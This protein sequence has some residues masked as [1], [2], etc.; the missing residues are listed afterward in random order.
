MSLYNP[1]SWFKKPGKKTV[2]DTRPGFTP[3]PKWHSLLA[4]RFPHFKDS[5]YELNRRGYEIIRTTDVVAQPMDKMANRIGMMVPVVVGRGERCEQ[6]QEIIDLSLGMPD[7]L[8]FLAWGVVEGWRAMWIN[9]YGIPARGYVVPDLRGGGI[10]RFQA[11]G[12][13]MWDG[14]TENNVIKVEQPTHPDERERPSYLMDR[15]RIILFRPGASINPDGENDVAYQLL[16]IAE[17]ASLL[18]KAQ[19]I[20]GERHALPREIIQ[21]L[22]ESLRPDE[23]SAAVSSAAE[24]IAATNAYEITGLTTEQVLKYLEPSGTTWQFLVEYRRQ[25]EGRAHKIISGENM[26]SD[27]SGSGPSG[28]TKNA[29]QQLESRSLAIAKKLSEPL[30]HDLLSWCER[31][32]EGRLAPLG[33]DEPIPYIQLRP[34]VEK[35]RLSIAEAVQLMDRGWKFP[36]NY[37]C[38]LAGHER[39]PGTDDI[40]EPSSDNGGGDS[41]IDNDG[42]V[43]RPDRAPE[44]VRVRKIM[45]EDDLRNLK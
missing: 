32:N 16:L 19:R 42:R 23:L 18:D 34:P 13:A 28:S 37:I 12:L 29:Q 17:Q 5:V 6:L 33:A 44:E 22:A 25:L 7:A 4:S 38:E 21:I 9:D 41:E 24:K 1:F 8:E 10:M 2:P 36:T 31:K 40:F 43:M 15:E 45:P 14:W 3:V 30:T 39:V 20:Y 11:G 27:T 35:T 26:T